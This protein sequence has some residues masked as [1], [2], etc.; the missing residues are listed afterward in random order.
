MA[1]KLMFIP[2]DDTQNNPFCRIDYNNWLK[3]LYTIL[4]VP[5]NENSIKVPKVYLWGLV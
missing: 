2:D 3:C 4:N 5:T 1:D